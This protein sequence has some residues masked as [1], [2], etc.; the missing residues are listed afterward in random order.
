MKRTLRKTAPL[1]ENLIEHEE[2]KGKNISIYLNAE[3]LRYL[4]QLCKL[5]GWNRS[6]TIQDMILRIK[7]ASLSVIPMLGDDKSEIAEFIRKMA[8]GSERP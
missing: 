8:F 6:K 5:Y 2:T 1:S 7:K 4:D 3:S